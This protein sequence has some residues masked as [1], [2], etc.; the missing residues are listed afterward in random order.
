M[1]IFKER[2]TYF[3]GVPVFLFLH[4]KKIRIKIKRKRLLGA[5]IK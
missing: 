5:Q 3:K 4:R 1:R 2:D